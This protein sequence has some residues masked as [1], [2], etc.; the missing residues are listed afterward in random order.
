MADDQRP[1]ASTPYDEDFYAWTQRQAEAIA[2]AGK[3]GQLPSGLDWEILAEEVGDLG[4]RDYRECLSRVR[5]IL[6]HLWKL[7]T[8][9]REEPKGHWEEEILV[10]RADLL[11]VLTP[12]L[13]RMVGTEL[14]ALHSEAARMATQ[15]LRSDEP[16]ALPLDASKRWTLAQILAEHDDPNV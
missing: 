2:A 8:T 13:R 7:D 11:R 1:R 12:T 9:R 14:E 10:Q 16:A 6:I 3:A 5:Q 4:K 15:S